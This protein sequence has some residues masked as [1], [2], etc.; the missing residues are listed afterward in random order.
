MIFRLASLHVALVQNL[1]ILNL[2]ISCIHVIIKLLFRHINYEMSFFLI[3]SLLFRS[4]RDFRGD[5]RGGY[6]GGY[7]REKYSG[8]YRGGRGNWRSYNDRRG[9]GGKWIASAF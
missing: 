7:D 1:Q 8:G 9:G 4:D 6:R 2:N 5:R 3:F